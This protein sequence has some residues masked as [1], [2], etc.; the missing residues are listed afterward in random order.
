MCHPLWVA[1]RTLA[2]IV[3]RWLYLCPA[4]SASAAL[5]T[6]IPHVTVAHWGFKTLSV[7]PIAV[8][9]CYL[10]TIWLSLKYNYFQVRCGHANINQDVQSSLLL[11]AWMQCI[12]EHDL[13]LYGWFSISLQLST[14]WHSVKHILCCTVPQQ[15]LCSCQCASSTSQIFIHSLDFFSP[16]PTNNLFHIRRCTLLWP[17]PKWNIRHA[18]SYC[19]HS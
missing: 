9:L 12:Y 6:S 5:F 18:H 4:I 15:V 16:C 11:M 2:D 13:F 8:L 10:I 3:V 14:G 7:M 1:P 17:R 19:R